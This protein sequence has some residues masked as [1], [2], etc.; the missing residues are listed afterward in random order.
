MESGEHTSSRPKIPTEKQRAAESPPRKA[1]PS[2]KA[3]TNPID[4]QPSH[5]AIPGAMHGTVSTVALAGVST[6]ALAVVNT[7]SSMMGN[8][9]PIASMRAL[10]WCS[11]EIEDV[12]DI[13]EMFSEKQSKAVE[14]ESL[15]SEDED[16]GTEPAESGDNL[17]EEM[18]EHEL[19][20]MQCKW[21]ALVYAFFKP[22]PA[23]EY[24]LKSTSN[25]RKHVLKCWGEEALEAVD[26]MV[27]ASKAKDS[28]EKYWQSQ[29][30][31]VAFGAVG[32]KMFHYSTIQH[33]PTETR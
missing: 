19:A 4:A 9:G 5:K 8:Q 7:T 30:I 1:K 24:D 12:E 17:A 11:I 20:C 32:K 21:T 10:T 29:G 25:L 28:I 15:S 16:N 27:T 6:A 31:K 23:I 33:T 26:W 18:A 14:I 13:D 3:C 2:K 22:D